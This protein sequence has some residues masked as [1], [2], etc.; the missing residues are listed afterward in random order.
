[1]RLWAILLVAMIGVPAMAA[2]ACGGGTSVRDAALHLQWVVERDCVH[3]ERPAW[4]V[5]VP[6]T[7]QATAAQPGMNPR[8]PAPLASP[9]VRS[10]MTVLLGHSND[11][12]EIHLRGTV[13]ATAHTG[14]RVRVRAGLGAV[15]LEGIV[16]GPG[17]V[18][19]LPRKGGN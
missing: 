7:A 9:D 17:L 11:R 14:E 8:E 16:R 19:L 5:A 4:L 12:A 2:G 1:M 3:P 13:L 6:W 10:G 15:A 18:E